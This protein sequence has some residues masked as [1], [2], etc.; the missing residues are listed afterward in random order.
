MPP[1]V[2][3]IAL[4]SGEARSD[5][6]AAEAATGGSSSNSPP[7]APEPEERKSVREVAVEEIYSF[8]LADDGGGCGDRTDL[9]L[10]VPGGVA[11]VGCTIGGVGG[12]DAVELSLFATS[13]A[14][15]SYADQLESDLGPFVKR[16][17]WSYGNGP[18]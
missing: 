3:H 1:R 18:T 11:N 8:F 15:R 16:L 9:D 13:Q 7:P 17:S 2:Q 14:V 12:I 10:A 4:V 5:T 6:P